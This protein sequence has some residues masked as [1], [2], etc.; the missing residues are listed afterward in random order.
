M[1]KIL[2]LSLEGLRYRLKLLN[3]VL[4]EGGKC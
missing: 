3:Y 2:S 4:S 1:F